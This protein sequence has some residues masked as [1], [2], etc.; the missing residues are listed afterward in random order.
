[1]EIEAKKFKF[2]SSC[3]IIMPK[4][5]NNILKT[6]TLI[7]DQVFFIFFSSCILYIFKNILLDV[8]KKQPQN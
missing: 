3:K 6:I 2:S 5:R 4:E 7:I 1:M 8:N